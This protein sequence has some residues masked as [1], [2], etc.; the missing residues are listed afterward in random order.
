MSAGVIQSHV[1]LIT[2]ADNCRDKVFQEGI[3]YS[4]KPML[5]WHHN[6]LCCSLHPIWAASELATGLQQSMPAQALQAFQTSCKAWPRPQARKSTLIRS[7]H[8]PRLQHALLKCSFRDCKCWLIEAIILA[9][10]CSIRP[11]ISCQS[12]CLSTPPQARLQPA[13]DL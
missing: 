7:N 6:I 3:G 1:N 8:V 12:T 11:G 9:F 4:R 13:L 10:C 2:S 5:N